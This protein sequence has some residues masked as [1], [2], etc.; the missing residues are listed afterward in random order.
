MEE[1]LARITK[2]ESREVR[3]AIWRE[4]DCTSRFGRAIWRFL[5]KTERFVPKV[6]PVN[7]WM[8]RWWPIIWPSFKNDLGI[9]HEDKR[10]T[11]KP[12]QLIEQFQHILEQ[13]RLSHAYLFTGAF[14]SFEMAPSQSL[15]CE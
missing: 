2:S 10:F 1:G 4:L 15:F 14:G 7:L 11:A 13:G 6:V 8:I 5:T 12:V 3:S 9:R